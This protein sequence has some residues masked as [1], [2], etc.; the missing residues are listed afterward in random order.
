MKKSVIAAIAFAA[1]LAAQ[2]LESSI[3]YQ[4][5]LRD[6]QGAVLAGTQYTIEFRLY[7]QASGG[8]PLWGRSTVVILD[9]NGLFNVELADSVGSDVGGT[10]CTSLTEALAQSRGGSLYVGLT[11]SNSSGEISPRQ[12]IMSVPYATY[13]ADVSSAGGDFAVAGKTTLR[14][15][16]AQTLDVAGN[17]GVG[18][19]A[20]FSQGVTV[21]GN[22]SVSKPNAISGRGTVPIGAIVIW[23]GLIQSI[24]DGWALCDGSNNTPDLRD[25]FVMG[26]S[27]EVGE[28]GG[29]R[30]VTLSVSH[31]PPH[32]H[33]YFSD[34]QIEGRDTKYGTTTKVA[35]MPGYDANSDLKGNSKVYRTSST[36]GSNGAA[37]SFSILP[38]YYKFAYIM[39][40]H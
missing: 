13:A 19:N 9:A 7:T 16:E 36:G 22:L 35:S 37:K 30:D 15:A 4:G 11:V 31:L 1:A 29:S 5:I 21:N 28:R 20:V 14:D 25:R 24:P 39:R 38:P 17:V 6:D 27:T 33:N 26:T 10:R 18:G 23:S 3:A 12:K 2:A 34:D 40:V 32:T 8:T